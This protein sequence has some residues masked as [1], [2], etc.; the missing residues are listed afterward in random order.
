[1]RLASF[2]PYLAMQM[3]RYYVASDWTA[4][5]RDVLV[6][7]PQELSLEALRGTGL[8]P[9]ETALP[10]DAPAPAVATPATPM[11]V[12][13]KHICMYASTVPGKT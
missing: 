9:D 7:A 11:P 6:E 4:K 5:K 12:G 2:P 1:M 3:R 13:L 10:E 8:Q